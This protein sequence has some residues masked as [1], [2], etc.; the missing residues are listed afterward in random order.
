M[1]KKNNKTCIVCNTRY[2]FCT[3]C[4]DFDYEPR[5]KALFHDENCKK[6]FSLLTEYNAGNIDKETAVNSM[7]ELDL[8]D[9]SK[10]KEKL[11]NEINDLLTIE[12]PITIKSEVVEITVE[13]AEYATPVKRKMKVKSVAK[14]NI[15]TDIVTE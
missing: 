15:E 11:Q 7:K 5:W 9:F 12:E 1:I 2:T 13:E 3:H 10:F 4:S 14:E 8:S 6:I